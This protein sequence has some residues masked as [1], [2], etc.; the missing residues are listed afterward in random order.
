MTL[1]TEIEQS[2]LQFVWKHKRPQV[3]KA[4]LSKTPMLEIAQYPTSNYTSHRNKNSMV[5]AQKTNTK[6][7]ATE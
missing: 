4:I 2:I 1:I 3:A 7:S 5:L 6:T